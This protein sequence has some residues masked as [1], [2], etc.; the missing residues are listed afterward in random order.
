MLH[1]AVDEHVPFR[2]LEPEP[3]RSQG[4]T[5][6][7]KEIFGGHVQRFRRAAGISQTEL[8]RKVECRPDHIA[9]IEN[10][11]ANVTFNEA[12]RIAV[13]LSRDFK[14]WLE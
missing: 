2:E 12:I 11:T 14:C 10:G 3:A 5:L 13:A 8:A 4:K 7:P 1:Q 6:S 9:N